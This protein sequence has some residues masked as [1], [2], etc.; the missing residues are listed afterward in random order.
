MEALLLAHLPAA[1]EGLALELAAQR[2]Q[3]VKSY[4]AAQK[5]PEARL[6]LAAPKAATPDENWTPQ[7]QLSLAAQ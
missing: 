6:F 1:T 5:L 2:G 7:A 3:A 4:L